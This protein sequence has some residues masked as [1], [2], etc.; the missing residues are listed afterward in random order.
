[1]VK[2]EK[3]VCAEIAR[4]DGLHAQQFGG[5]GRRDRDEVDG[6]AWAQVTRSVLSADTPADRTYVTTLQCLAFKLEEHD[7]VDTPHGPARVPRCLRGRNFHDP[8]V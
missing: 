1:M 2:S 7:M 5:R 6:A 4:L 8:Q 3:K